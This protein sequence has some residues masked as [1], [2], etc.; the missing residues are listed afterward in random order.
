MNRRESILTAVGGFLGA[1]L[2]WGAKAE[3]DWGPPNDA[4]IRLRDEAIEANRRGECEP[5]D[6]EC[7]QAEPDSW[8]IEIGG[9]DDGPQFVRPLIVRNNSGHRIA[10]GQ[11]VTYSNRN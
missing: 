9:C 6:C 3:D 5:L 10:A 1:L 4:M 11:V 8:T 7:C 2:P